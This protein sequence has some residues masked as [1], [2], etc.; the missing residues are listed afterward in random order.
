MKLLKI[1]IIEDSKEIVEAISLAVQ[2]RWPDFEILSSN[3]GER[4][5]ELAE[6][7]TPDIIILDIG[8]PDI[9]GFEVLKSVRLFS[10]VPILILTVRSEEAIIVK[11][12]ELGADDYM[13]KPFKQ[14]EL[15]ARVNAIIRR[16]TPQ[17]E[18]L[19]AVG[20][21]RLDSASLTFTNNQN[22]IS[23]TR[24]EA[25]ILNQL[26]RNKGNVVDHATLAEAVWGRDYPDSAN[27]L[28]VHIRRLRQKI[29]LDANDPHVIMTKPGVGY[30]LGKT[31]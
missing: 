18:E 13:I 21:M 24:T 3:L 27:A 25:T 20:Q 29:E 14:L 22:Q 4:G 19:L 5:I 26:M 2:I 6:K 16:N 1:L 8:L 15:L 17:I 30:M 31:N 28:K 12:L 9:S 11:G 7:E 23:L 10:K